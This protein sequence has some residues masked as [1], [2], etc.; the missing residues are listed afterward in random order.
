MDANEQRMWEYVNARWTDMQ[1]MAVGNFDVFDMEGQMNV[2]A[3]YDFTIRREQQIAEVEEE[4][5]YVRSFVMMP[6]IRPDKEEKHP[7]W[8]RILAVE[9]D[10]LKALRQG[11]K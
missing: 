11:M 2:Q 6:K 4:I 3:A 5:A 1:P 7:V 9:Q 8:N 10:R